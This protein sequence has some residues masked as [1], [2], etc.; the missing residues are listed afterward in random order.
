[1]VP[2]F[3]WGTR[4]GLATSDGMSAASALW[5]WTLC[6]LLSVATATE[7]HS[8]L[9]GV[10]VGGPSAGW[11]GRIGAGGHWPAGRWDWSAGG[12]EERD[13][14]LTCRIRT[15]RWISFLL[16]IANKRPK[17][18]VAHLHINASNFNL[19]KHVAKLINIQKAMANRVYAFSNATT[20][21]HT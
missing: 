19:F 17:Q 16:L 10:S 8:H 12:G 4:W 9:W 11:P 2:H 15:I 13:N 7:S 3:G 21:A 18:P 5:P 20:V 1:V 14:E 6:G